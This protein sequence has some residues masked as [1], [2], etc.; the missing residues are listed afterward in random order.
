MSDES[1]SVDSLTDNSAVQL[2]LISL[3]GMIS[4]IL[5]ERVSVKLGRQVRTAQEKLQAQAQ[6][7]NQNNNN[8]AESIGDGE[9]NARPDT[10]LDE[11]MFHN[12]S[13]NTP[14]EEMKAPVDKLNNTDE[15]AVW[16]KSKVVSRAHA[17]IWLKDGQVNSKLI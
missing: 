7:Q 15:C 6:E 14:A 1:K 10:T 16:F 5:K 11:T 3:N 8:P 4:R 17:E 9:L 12:S 2:R 13:I